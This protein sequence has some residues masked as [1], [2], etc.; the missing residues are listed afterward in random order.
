MSKWAFVDDQH[1]PSAA[2]ADELSNG[3]ADLKVEVLAPAEARKSLLSSDAEIDGALI[4]V[5]LS[6]VPGEHGSGPGLAQDIRVNQENGRIRS[7]PLVRF[8]SRAKVLENIGADSSS[9]DLFDLKI[10]KEFAG[11]NIAAVRKKLIG[12]SEVYREVEECPSFAPKPLADFLG[13]T[14]DAL[15]SWTH[16]EFIV[17]AETARS[18]KPHIASGLIM[19]FLTQPGPLI[20]EGLLAVRLGVDRTSEG[21]AAVRDSLDP[22]KYIGKGR[23]YFDLWWAR[24]VEDW[25]LDCEGAETPL[26][27]MT[28]EQR[29]EQLAEKHPG[30]V[31]LKM[32]P[33]SWGSRP[34]RL[35]ALSLEEEE[36]SLVPVDPAF[37]VRVASRGN[38]APWVDPNVA[39]L[40][41]AL[42]HR[43]DPRLSKADFERHA[44]LWQ[45]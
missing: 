8:S 2:F 44:S 32:P 11:R 15:E 29:I 41:V 23:G 12:C 7:F 5:D 28:I 39:A 26:S 3:G 17:R 20:K 27:S 13:L 14:V 33:E 10:D 34:W 22:V 37:G 42:Q 16:P 19:K 30:L 43:S 6:D 25:W 40:G 31:G 38:V 18:D 24:G 4:D 36:P 35:C 9:D 1:D 21:W 45:K